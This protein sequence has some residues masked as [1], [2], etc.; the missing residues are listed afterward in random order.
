ML[1]RGDLR[2]P[3]ED[4]W[5]CVDQR[6]PQGSEKANRGPYHEKLTYTTSFIKRD[7]YMSIIA[8]FAF[9]ALFA[10]FAILPTIIQRNRRSP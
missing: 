9:V 3:R 4:L 2:S 1:S 8:V 5:P 6:S 7:N 10:I